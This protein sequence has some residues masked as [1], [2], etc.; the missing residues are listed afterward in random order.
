MEEYFEIVTEEGKV[1]GKAMRSE[2]HNNP[3]LLHRVAH[4]L[5]FNSQGWLFL[6]KRSLK[7]DIQPGKWDTSCGGHLDIG[8]SFEDAAYRELYE[9][10]GIKGVRLYYLHDYIW[11]TERESELVR[12]YKVVYDGEITFNKEEIE[13]GRF[14]TQAQIES[15]L[16]SGLLTPNFEEEYR[17]YKKLRNL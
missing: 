8:E 15:M 6:Q 13:E 2:C 14:F 4:V 9:E 10:L 12:T 3:E 5:V 7:K 16:G 17:R 11:R 1:I